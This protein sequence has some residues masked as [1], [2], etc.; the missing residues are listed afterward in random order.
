MLAQRL[1][2]L[3]LRGLLARL[4][5]PIETSIK[6]GWTARRRVLQALLLV[7]LCIG[8]SGQLVTAAAAGP[9]LSPKESKVADMVRAETIREITVALT[10]DAMEGRGTCQPGGETAAKYIADRFAGIGLKPRGDKG[11]FFQGV[12]FQSDQL[13]SDS[14]LKIGDHALALGVDFVYD[15]SDSDRETVKVEGDL[16][17]VDNAT[18]AKTQGSDP[19]KGKI[20]VVV[21]GSPSYLM[22]A[23]RGALGIVITLNSP[24]LPSY[25]AGIARERR[26]VPMDPSRKGVIEGVPIAYVPR[27]VAEKL[28]EKA[29]R[30]YHATLTRAKARQPFACD[31]G[32][33]AEMVR[34]VTRKRLTSSNVVG[35]LEGSD[36]RLKDEAVVYSAHY[37]AYGKDASG[38]V[39]P[40][41]ADNALGVAKMLALAE[42]MAKSKERPRRS[43][44]FL[45]TTAEEMGMVGSR[46]WVD[47]P[48]WPMPKIA[49]DLNLDGIDTDTYGPIG[50]IVG[51]GLGNSSLDGVVGEVSRDMHLLALPEVDLGT[52]S[53][54]RSDQIEFARMG[55][56]TIFVFPLGIHPPAA[57]PQPTAGGLLGSLASLRSTAGELADVVARTDDFLAKHY[58]QPSDV[59]RPN[60]DWQGVRTAAVFYL[61]AGLRVANAEKVPTWRPDSPYNHRRG[62]RAGP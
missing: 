15:V 31:L 40:G 16:V 18:M 39:R 17:C 47:H 23:R 56:P 5:R 51:S 9:A 25:L 3:C 60:W 59:I 44:I 10:C 48:T 62:E 32:Q 22:I 57:G 34:C 7:L 52:R 28:F 53:Y 43:I 61:V 50:Y 36:P 4:L 8:A 24:S 1:W 54:Y 11:S 14:T 35:L 46:Y 27:S 33:K 49:A 21:S 45:A 12:P 38:Q 55:V 29:P 13:R 6:C 58:H 20:A 41:A 19:L 2:E 42:A 30:S 37:D 26:L